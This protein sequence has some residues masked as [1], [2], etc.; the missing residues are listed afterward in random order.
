MKKKILLGVLVMLALTSNAQYK[1][2]IGLAFGSPSGISYKT[3]LSRNNALDFTLGGLN[4][5]FIFSG[6]YEIHTPLAND[7]Q[8]YYGAGAH[9]GS[10]N[11]G[12]YG[13]GTFLGADG[14]LGIEFTPSVPFVFSLDLRPAI[15]LVGNNYDNEVHLFWPQSQFA[16]RYRF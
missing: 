10:W 1:N 3:F 4:N 14:V 11:G 6:L 9:L 12:K 8:W 13:S 5:Y 16:V 15:N 7:F 2:A